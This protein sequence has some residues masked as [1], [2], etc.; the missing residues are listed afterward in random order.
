MR[1]PSAYNPRYEGDAKE[2]AGSWDGVHI[3]PNRPTSAIEVGLAGAVLAATEPLALAV[4]R[5]HCHWLELGACAAHV[6][7]PWLA[8][9]LTTGAPI[10]HSVLLHMLNVGPQ[11]W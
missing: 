10:V 2:Q 6:V 1:D 4:D 9:R 8:H 11:L 5:D 7:A 3:H